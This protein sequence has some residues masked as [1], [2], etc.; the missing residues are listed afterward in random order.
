M[1]QF[2]AL[3]IK[4]WHT[5]KHTFLIPSY[6]LASF[7]TMSALVSIYALIRYGGPNLY[8]EADS[9][10]SAMDALRSLYYVMSVI[11]GWFAIVASLPLADNLLNQDYH[12]KCEIMHHSQPVSLIKML[13]AKLSLAIP[14]M[15]LQ[16]LILAIIGWFIVASVAAILGFNSWGFGLITI[17]SPMPLVFVSML[18]LS[19]VFWLFSCAFRKQAV[20]KLWISFVVIDLLRQMLI[21]LWQVPST[22][23]LVNHYFRILTLPLSL[24]SMQGAQ[25]SLVLQRAFSQ[26]NLV[27]LAV[28]ILMYIAGYFIYKRRE[29]S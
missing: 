17:L 3:V 25:V 15:L 8:L 7:F 21:R 29:L 28:S 16:Y 22:F 1:R 26:K 11:L 24:L 6:V 12:K 19:S 18:T 23:S 27:S 20:M 5:H 9:G 13:A 14:L 10:F 4:E 2:K